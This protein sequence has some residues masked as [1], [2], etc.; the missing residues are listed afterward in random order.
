MNPTRPGID[1]LREGIDIGGLEF[2]IGPVVEDFGSRSWL[3]A[4]SSRLQHLSKNRSSSFCGLQLQDF[5]EDAAQLLWR[6][7]I[8]VRSGEAVYL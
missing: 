7:D 8:E 1:E 3:L 5:K 6:V 4:S 2:V